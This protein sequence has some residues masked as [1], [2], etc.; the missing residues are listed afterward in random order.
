VPADAA[1]RALTAAT[2]ALPEYP[3][4][5]RSLQRLLDALDR[6]SSAHERA[7]IV[8]SDAGLAIAALRAGNGQGGDVCGAA[9][10][11]DVIGEAGLGRVA[12]ALP[13]F[14]SLAPADQ[15]AE[16]LRLHAAAVQ[17][18]AERVIG[19]LGSEES[20]D[21][22]TAALLHDVGKLAL[23]AAEPEYALAGDLPPAE[24]LQRE[25]L[26]HGIDHAAVGAALA[27]GWG[28]PD[29]LANTI[30]E[31]HSPRAQGAAAIVRLADMLGH[32][33]Q[34]A[35]VQVEEVEE[36]AAAIGL[37]R[38]AIGALLYE[39]PYPV[40][41]G[42][43]PQPCPLSLREL[44]VLRK[45]GEGKVYKQIAADEGIAPSTVR[46][47]LHSAYAKLGVVDRAQ[48]VL[49]AADHGWI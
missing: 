28:L 9:R 19:V 22:L 29:R 14:D 43:R 25:R 32:Y 3:A 17:R 4:H 1:G 11:V 7:A 38:E 8:Q 35:P 5:S 49:M 33:E 42:R 36:A 23:A 26:A 21:V 34:G 45:L 47:Y 48:A 31:H 44:T 37:G 10:A 20:D 12:E 40:R 16:R 27:G 41:S 18:A 46:N 24:R 39:L 2:A 15:A 30:A 6:R 13:T